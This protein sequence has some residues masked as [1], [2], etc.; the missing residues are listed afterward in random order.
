MADS[1]MDIANDGFGYKV[2]GSLGSANVIGI[3]PRSA[4]H[5][6]CGQVL[7]AGME[8]GEVT[9]ANRCNHRTGRRVLR[10]VSRSTRDCRDKA[11]SR[12]SPHVAD[13]TTAFA[14]DRLV[15]HA[16]LG[17]NGVA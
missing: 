9:R 10:S 13:P 15:G 17:V 6:S 1:G 3:A 14:V 2:W 8:L 4:H 11:F 12:L 7:P 16:P 5:C